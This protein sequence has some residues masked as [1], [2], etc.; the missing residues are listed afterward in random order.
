MSEITKSQILFEAAN[1]ID[2]AGWWNGNP[3]D[4]YTGVC[5]LQAISLTAS[6]YNRR[7]RS[8]V[9]DVFEKW[10]APSLPPLTSFTSIVPYWNDS[11]SCK[12]EVTSA[13]RACAVIERAKELQTEQQEVAHAH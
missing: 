6:T 10:V 1:L 7:I 12:E 8:V 3:G 11:R 2:K 4:I 5:A 13:L 9:M